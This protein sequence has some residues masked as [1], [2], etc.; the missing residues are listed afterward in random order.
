LLIILTT[1]ASP[2]FQK[3]SLEFQKNSPEFQK[4]SV[5]NS[6]PVPEKLPPL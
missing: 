5:K 1:T 2:D 6:R 4:N 3:N